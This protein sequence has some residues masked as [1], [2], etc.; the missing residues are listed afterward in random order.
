MQN[1]NSLVTKVFKAKYFKSCSFLEAK[2]GSN[3]SFVWKSI[4]ESQEVLKDNCNWRV[5]DGTSINVWTDPWLADAQFPFVQTE[6]PSYLRDAKVSS[7]MKV[8]DTGWDEE[9]IED[10]FMPE[11]RDKILSIP[12]PNTA[13]K[14]KLIWMGEEKGV[15]SVK[16]CYRLL[17]WEETPEPN[18]MWNTI[19]KLSLPP[20]VKVLAWQVCQNVLPTAVNLQSKRVECPI[21]CKLC[22]QE[23][24][25]TD[26]VFIH[27]GVAKACWR[28]VDGVE[29]L[30][31]NHVQE[32]MS[33][34]MEKLSAYNRCLL[35]TICWRLWGAR[36]QEVWNNVT[37]NHA[38]IFREARTYLD[39]WKEIHCKTTATKTALQ[40]EKWKKPP[41]NILKLNVDAA[42][43]NNSRTTGFGFIIRDHNGLF[44]AA[45][46]MNCNGLYHPKMAEA[47]GIREALNWI[48]S[49]GVT[50][51]Q[52]ESDALTVI[53][54]IN[55]QSDWT[56]FDF[57][58][59]DI[60]QAANLFL[61]ISFVF[62]R[63]SANMAAHKLAREAVF[64]AER[65]EWRQDPPSFLM[66]FHHHRRS[67]PTPPL[68]PP[69]LRLR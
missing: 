60:R 11:D 62:A 69:L 26:H 59:E 45:A 38:T 27:C 21:L 25:T 37:V 50:K 22:N 55:S 54:N 29:D 14:D 44:V 7:L 67:F 56:S 6:M 68:S 40:M 16:S 58:I 52:V 34:A 15:Y 47:I 51:V 35:L 66:K 61:D 41:E 28:Q 30:T 19:W 46:G 36:N 31:A 48:K 20:K 39:A 9:V 24:E 3:P 10:I 23:V 8:Q 33:T 65:R 4:M 64:S 42:L 53:Q 1:P 13:H 17:T 57:I 43:D 5:G 49:L 18:C 12:I 63:R 2:V 32:W